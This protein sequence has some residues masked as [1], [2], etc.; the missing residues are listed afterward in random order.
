VVAT[1]CCLA[2]PHA[3]ESG[4]YFNV[5][6]V[7]LA[8]LRVNERVSEK[9]HGE[10]LGAKERV[11]RAG[12][13]RS[14]REDPTLVRNQP[15][16]TSSTG[17]VWLIVGAVLAAICTAMLLLQIRNSATEAITGACVVVALYAAMVLVRVVTRP[18]RGRLTVMAALFGAMAAWTLIWLLVIR[19]I[20]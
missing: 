3:T 17:R 1:F 18:G 14:K 16:L 13:N 12:A 7:W 20:A 6:P 4:D 9:E 15:A 8:S 19:A 5:T 11:M 10:R 2:T